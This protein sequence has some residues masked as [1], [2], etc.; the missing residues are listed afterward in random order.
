VRHIKIYPPCNF[1]VNPITHFWVISLFPSNFQ[2]FNTFRRRKVLKFYKF[3][4]K[5]GNNSNKLQTCSACQ[6]L[7]TLQFWS[8]SDLTSISYSFWNIRQKVLKLKK[9]ID[10]KKREITP[11]WV[12]EF[13]SKLQCKSWYICI[14]SHYPFWSYFP[15]FIKFSQF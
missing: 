1:E 12:M 8:K 5:K 14:K 4:E 11:K 6:D 9:K 10:G 2:N 13:T 3:D 7:P 15:F